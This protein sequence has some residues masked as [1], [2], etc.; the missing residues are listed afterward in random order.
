[1]EY[2]KHIQIDGSRLFKED[3]GNMDKEQIKTLC[4]FLDKE[5]DLRFVQ[6]YCNENYSYLIDSILFKLLY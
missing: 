3:I 6:A 2:A 1:M 4:S 5:G